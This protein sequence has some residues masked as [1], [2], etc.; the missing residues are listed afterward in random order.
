MS[1]L[2]VLAAWKANR[3]LGCITRGMATWKGKT[4]PLLLCPHETPSGVLCPGL[5]PPAQEGYGAV[6]EGP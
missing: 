6:V 3:I 1:Q 4:T 5:G 2:C